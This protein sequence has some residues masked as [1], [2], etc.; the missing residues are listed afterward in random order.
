MKWLDDYL[1]PN[2]RRLKSG[3]KIK[4]WEIDTIKDWKRRKAIGAG[5]KW[6]MSEPVSGWRGRVPTLFDDASPGWQESLV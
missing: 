6:H 4:D 5:T 1:T 2:D 3:Y